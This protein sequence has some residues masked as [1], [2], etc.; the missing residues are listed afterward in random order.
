MIDAVCEAYAFVAMGHVVNALPL[1]DSGVFPF[2]LCM[3]I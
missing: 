3:L 1:V 2:G